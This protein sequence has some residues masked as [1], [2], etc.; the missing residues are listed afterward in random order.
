MNQTIED[1]I[2]NRPLKRQYEMCD[3]VIANCESL[4]KGPRTQAESKILFEQWE[5]ALDIR[6]AVGMKMIDLQFV[7]DLN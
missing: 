1:I 7:T 4:S 6:F 5:K 3:R 2:K